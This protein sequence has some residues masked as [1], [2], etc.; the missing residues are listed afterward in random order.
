MNRWMNRWIEGQVATIRR[1]KEGGKARPFRLNEIF[2]LLVRKAHTVW[3]P[4]RMSQDLRSSV[5]PPDTA[6][7][8]LHIQR[9]FGCCCWHRVASHQRGTHQSIHPTTT[10]TTTTTQQPIRS[11]FTIQPSGTDYDYYY[12]YH[13]KD[14]PTRPATWRTTTTTT[15]TRRLTTAKRGLWRRL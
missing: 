5:R 9:F 13:W 11:T 4:T 14:I 10:C 2:V 7:G 15:T 6:P 12:Y 1:S 3:P 8:S